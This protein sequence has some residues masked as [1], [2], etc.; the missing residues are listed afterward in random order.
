MSEHGLN[1]FSS[2]RLEVLV[3][4][5]AATMREEPL[6]PLEREVIVL[7]S[8]GMYRWLTLELATRLGIAAT[9]ATP[10]PGTFCLALAERI[11]RAR[12]GESRLAGAAERYEPSEASPFERNSLVWRIFRLLGASGHPGG[13]IADAYIKDDMDGTRRL[14]LADRLAE[15][16]DQYQLYRP[17]LL[18]AWE[19]REQPISTPAKRE[20]AEWQ[21]TLWR[22]LVGEIDAPHLGNRFRNLTA[23]LHEST[24]PSAVLPRRVS[25]FGAP[26]LP[27]LVLDL[28]VAL[29]R[30]TEVSI[31]LVSPTPHYWADIRSPKEAAALL[32]RFE[33]TPATDLHVE[34]GH[35]L[36]ATLGRQGRELGLLLHERDE[37]GEAWKPLDDET[38]SRDSAL[39]VLQADVVELVERGAAGTGAPQVELGSGDDT[40]QIHACHSPMREMQVI[41]DLILDAFIADPSLRPHEILVLAPRI[42]EYAPFIDAVFGVAHPHQPQIPYAIADRA[43]GAE[44]PSVDAALRA[45]DLATSRATV[46]ELFDF[47]DCGPVRAAAGLDPG[48]VEAARQWA[49]DA[50]VRWGRD[51]DHRRDILGTEGESFDT[52]RAG[53]D[54]LLLGYAMGNSDAL[55]RDV[56]ARGTA[57][58]EPAPLGRFA[59]FV[60]RWVRVAKDLER[61]RS[62]D[63]W[64]RDFSVLLDQFVMPVDES[65]ELALRKLREQLGD[66]T[67]GAK[68]ADFTEPVG[69]NVLR[70]R[71]RA[72]TEADGA[73][74]GFL[75]GGVTFC[76]LTPMRAIPAKLMIIAGLG[77]GAFPRRDRAVSYDLIAA[78]RR[79]GDRSPRD[80]DRY[81]FLETL[82]A[83]R[84]RLVLTFVGRSQRNN[85]PLAP[86]SVLADV[87]RTIDNTFRC[88]TSPISPASQAMIRE[89]ALQPFSERYFTSGAATDK[90]IFSFSEQDCR[91][92]AARRAA[93]GIARPFFVA[94]L[95]PVSRPSPAVELREVMELFAGASKYFCTRVLGLRLPQSDEKERD[96]EPFGSEPLAD[97]GRKVTMLEQR[98]G[99]RP[100][101]PSEIEL[102]R[103]THGLPHG[104]LGRARYERLRHEVDLMIATLRHAAGGDLSIL[105]PTAFEI[106]DSSWSL[107]GRLEGLTQG[108]L[109]LFRPAKL[110]AKDRVRA[111]IQHI[112]LCA[113]VERSRVPDTRTPPVAR[114]LLVGTDQTLLFRPV[115]NARD[116]LARLVA[117]VE[118]AGTTLLPWFPETAFEYAGKL[119]P[120]GKK[121]PSTPDEALEHA[122]KAF[123]RTDGPFWSSGESYDE[124][125]RLAWRGRDPLAGDAT[126]FQQISLEIYAPLLAAVE[127]LDEGTSDS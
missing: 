2:N 100:G 68:L 95:S 126:L 30:H 79:P 94:P 53:I 108:G 104:G 37:S 91:A 73:G 83:A 18:D 16:F 27:P 76:S 89:H 39:G 115:E 125:V 51:G 45:L 69:M 112:A 3:A 90:R 111:W 14:Q 56:L 26:S 58:G 124:Y 118:D 87:M 101:D 60:D 71:L 78:A 77:D 42:A 59:A 103:A 46:T 123:S 61:P 109:L 21:A 82:L 117:L 41:R 13:A 49:G 33:G 75:A 29:A 36:L 50:N 54:R 114:T 48:E 10:F 81:A 110:K 99:G 122:R 11:E 62:L 88:E 119:R 93:A 55:V 7:Q 25:V 80:D 1:V 47:L 92:A 8:R 40:I 22:E 98:L 102:L 43:L 4:K 24:G 15:R 20:T 57:A 85:S 105:E 86:S 34:T 12:K 44:A 32:A 84:S 113:H 66:I 52:W 107:A 31:Y 121:G 19:R 72:A 96:C 67:R 64:A 17:D 116:R 23:F 5:L 28:L 63:E 97:Y 38:P 6:G 127:P 9:I 120:S 65:D 35:P 106:V 70:N 74:S